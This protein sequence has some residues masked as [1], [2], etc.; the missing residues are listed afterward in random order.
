M[1]KSYASPADKEEVSIL[2]LKFIIAYVSVN[3]S[4]DQTSLGMGSKLKNEAQ[5]RSYG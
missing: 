3:I 2:A 5:K 4:D 1:N